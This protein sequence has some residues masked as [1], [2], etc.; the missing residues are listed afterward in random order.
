MAGQD[1]D[2]PYRIEVWDEHDTHVEELVA[3][4][5]DHAVA[6]AAFEEAIRRRPSKTI[7]LRQRAR[8]LAQSKGSS[9]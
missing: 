4:I 9:Q 5:G 8:V 6:R 1:T 7:T 3:L 2:L